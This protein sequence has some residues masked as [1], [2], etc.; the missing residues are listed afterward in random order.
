MIA[1]LIFA[2]LF[3]SLFCSFA[4]NRHYIAVFLVVLASG[5]IRVQW[6]SLILVILFVAILQFV[7]VFFSTKQ[8]K[9]FLLIL[10][11]PIAYMLLIL[12]I[13]PYTINFY[14]YLGYLAAMFV[15]AWVMLLKWDMGK[16]IHFLTAYGS[17]LI[18]TGFLEKIFT[19]NSRVGLALTV[20]TAYAV[21]LVIAWV[22]WVTNIF[23]SKIYSFKVILFGTFLVFLAIIFSGTRMGLLG[24]FIGIGLCSLSAIVIKEKSVVKIAAY[25]IGIVV[26]LL[27]SSVIV[28]NLL[29]SDLI[30]KKAFSSLLSGKLDD[31]NTGRVVMWV[32]AIDMFDNNKL[33]GIGAGNFYIKFKEFLMN[34]GLYHSG[35]SA[36]TMH[37]HNINSH[38]HNI[39]LMLLVEHGIVGFITLSI[40]VFLCLSQIFLYFLK[41]RQDPRFYAFFSGF[42]IIAILG[43]VDSI[44][45]YLSTVG[46]A[47]W[48]LGTCA[49]FRLRND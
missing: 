6:Q 30:V 9:S 3:L 44:P 11:L 5:Q 7:N 26:M 45:M 13:Q 37:M 19:N 46:F 12:L 40:F 18:F 14:N 38:A 34:T 31:S 16:I 47:A 22:I 33:F 27:L 36:V 28:W 8:N 39:Y 17:F 20:A 42:I 15:F 49:S 2:L 21:V 43:F 29:P 1:I 35:S 10:L 41:N 4:L 32:S 23:L 48:L 25:A 24:F